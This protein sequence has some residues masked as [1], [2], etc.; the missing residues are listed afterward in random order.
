[1]TNYK[2]VK[3]LINKIKPDMVFHLASNA[4]VRGVFDIPIVHAKNNNIITVNLL[5]A[6]RRSNLDPKIMICSTS[7]VYGNVKKIY[8]YN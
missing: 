3:K 8:A 2:S 7:E 1:M 4:D 5:E 6:I